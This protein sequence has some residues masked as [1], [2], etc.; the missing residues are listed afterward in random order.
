MASITYVGLLDEARR[1]RLLSEVAELV[2]DEPQPFTL[3]M[4]ADVWL[5]RRV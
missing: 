3:S 2:R 4:F 1:E 5:T